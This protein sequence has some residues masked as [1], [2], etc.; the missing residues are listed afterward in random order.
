MKLCGLSDGASEKV[1]WSIHRKTEVEFAR[2]RPICA[3]RPDGGR[4][5]RKPSWSR[6]C[7]KV[8]G[9]LRREADRIF[10]QP[11]RSEGG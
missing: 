5:G 8:R 9:L 3:V 1:D 6:I 4:H 10:N 11:I 2:G 7:E